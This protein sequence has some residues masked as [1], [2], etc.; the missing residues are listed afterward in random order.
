M[1]AAP[2][3]LGELVDA[4]TRAR[5]RGL[6]IRVAGTG[7]SL[8]PLAATPGCLVSTEHLT[9]ILGIDGDLIEVEAGALLIDVEEAAWEVGL[10]LEGGTNYGRMTVGGIVA[11]GAHGSSRDGGTLSSRVVAATIVTASGEVVYVDAA[12]PDDLRAARLHLGMLGVVYSLTLRCEPAFHMRVQYRPEPLERAIASVGEVLARHDHVSL[13]WY[14]GSRRGW[15]YLADRC[16][17]PAT[18]GRALLAR[19]RV[20]QYA[21]NMGA[22][23]AIFPI[24]RR[25]P[26]LTHTLLALGD[27]TQ[28]PITGEVRRSV[29]A[30]HYLWATPAF[31]DAGQIFGAE[32]AREALDATFALLSDEARAGRFPVNMAVQLRMLGPDDAWLSPTLGRP[33]V[34]LECVSAPGTP[35][36]EP[37][38]RAFTALIGDRFAGRP[39]WGKQFFDPARLAVYGARRADFERV[40]RRFDPAGVFLNDLTR[41]LLGD[42]LTDADRASR[43]IA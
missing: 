28:R 34:A 31:S 13:Y 1:R 21:L 16:P 9:R 38:F 25:V 41:D 23:S 37:F 32:H 11:T 39:H 33:A 22:G 26:R 36:A 18:L 4:V 12:R 20:Q 42:A 7:H 14:P 5:E 6:S 43:S 35:H 10:S 8:M 19:R 15:W 27:R 40:R 3:D 17:G 29:D 2:R 30:F 24:V